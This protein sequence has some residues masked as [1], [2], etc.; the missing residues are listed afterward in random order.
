VW[1]DAIP[2]QDY[3]LRIYGSL[4]NMPYTL[5]NELIQI[6]NT[7]WLCPDM[8]IS[9]DEQYVLQND[10]YQYNFGANLNFVVNFCYVSAARKNIT[11]PN[12]VTDP[13]QLATYID[14]MRVAHKFVRQF[15]NPSTVLDY[16][17]MEYI[18]EQR[19]ESD[20]AIDETPANYFLSTS[21]QISFYDNKI[22]DF[23]SFD[24]LPVNEYEFFA[25]KY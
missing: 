14:H 24:F 25:T 13:T 6:N 2:C 4:D 19:M 22:F 18:G 20:F 17:T 1:Y 11:D 5:R 15:F 7:P 3:Y 10:P 9:S 23:S 12:C 8:P 21:N 16:H